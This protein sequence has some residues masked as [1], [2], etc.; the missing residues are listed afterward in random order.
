MEHATVRTHAPMP[1]E[2]V[3]APSSMEPLQ[4]LSRP[5]QTS[6]VPQGWQ[7]PAWSQ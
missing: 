6:G 2:R 5:S 3:G 7:S 4:S 1:H